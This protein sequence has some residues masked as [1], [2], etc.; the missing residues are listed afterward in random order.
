MYKNKKILAIIPARN[1]SKGVK[2]KNIKN[3]NG[4]PMIAYTIENAIESKIF[5][6]VVVSTD[7]QEY[8]DI[9]LRYG[10]IIPSLRPDHLAS[11]T[12]SSLDMTLYTIDSLKE[13]G[14]EYDYFMLLQPTSPLRTTQDIL[15]SVGLLFEKNA[16]TVV[17]VCECEH[18]PQWSVELDEKLDLTV[19]EDKIKATRRQ[20]IKKSYR[21]NG[22]I[23]LSNIDYYIKNKS[24]Y[25]SNAIA[26]IMEYENSIDID[27]IYDFML[28][29]SV[30]KGG[31]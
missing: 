4:K 10:E 20:D 7:S 15:N 19:L 12:A 2:N 26:Y 27:S 28:A 22:A 5:D 30:M 31:E 16:N 8:I 9:S 6:D 1:G 18:P 13:Q 24:F 14:K 25:T 29:E 11:D 23:F 21:L 17:S 3:L